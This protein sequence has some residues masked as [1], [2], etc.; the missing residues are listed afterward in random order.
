MNINGTLIC[1]N[2][3]LYCFVLKWEQRVEKGQRDFET[4]SATVRKEVARFDKLRV[5]DFKSSVIQYL[6]N[7]MEKQQQVSFGV[8]SSTKS[9]I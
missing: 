9:F 7:L 6:Q 3:Y 1:Q 8:S 4:I 2:I 5:G